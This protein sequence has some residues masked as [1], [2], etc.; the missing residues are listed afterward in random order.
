MAVNYLLFQVPEFLAPVEC[1]MLSTAR[2]KV[3]P[4]SWEQFMLR[5]VLRTCAYIR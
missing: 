1:P 2:Q 5:F 4:V 3:V